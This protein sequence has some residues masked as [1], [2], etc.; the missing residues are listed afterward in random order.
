MFEE[1]IER[2]Q[3]YLK[4]HYDSKIVVDGIIG[5]QTRSILGAFLKSQFNRRNWSEFDNGK[6]IIW[7]RYDKSYNNKFNDYCILLYNGVIRVVFR[8]TTTPGNFWI[9]NPVT[10]GGITGVACLCEQ[11]VINS[12]VWVEKDD[13]STLWLK[14]P[15]AAQ[16]K[17]VS[18]Y[19]DGNKDSVFDRNLITIG[20]PSSGINMHQM[21]AGTVNWNWSAGCLGTSREDWLKITA[22]YDN[23]DLITL[24]LIE[25]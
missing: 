24:N 2:I 20:K 22:R 17:S 11:Q 10:V 16:K 3:K 14:T 6:Q 8:A 23:G 9:Y 15:Y 12:H 19:R 21:G 7:L 18:I 25:L 1:H 4:L 13:W 5:Q